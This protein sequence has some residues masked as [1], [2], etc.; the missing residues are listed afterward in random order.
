MCSETEHCCITKRRELRRD[1]DYLLIC[2]F[3][4]TIS[5]LRHEIQK[6][7]DYHFSGPIEMKVV[8]NKASSLFH[9]IRKQ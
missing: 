5:A 1:L 9:F 6:M 2:K 7:S 4:D 3:Q 8:E